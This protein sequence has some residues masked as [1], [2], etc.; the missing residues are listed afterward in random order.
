MQNLFPQQPLLCENTQLDFVYL[1]TY[2]QVIIAMTF[3]TFRHLVF[4]V[5]GTLSLLLSS[6][7]CHSNRKSPKVVKIC[8]PSFF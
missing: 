7:G 2:E 8:T 3:N 1:I 5:I 6:F 4:Y